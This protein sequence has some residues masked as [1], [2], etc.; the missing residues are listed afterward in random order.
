M[1][2]VI[3]GDLK[4]VVL[5][6]LQVKELDP[7]NVL[8]AKTVQRLTP[9]VEERREKMKDEMM[10]EPDHVGQAIVSGMPIRDIEGRRPVC[11]ICKRMRSRQCWRVHNS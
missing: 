4:S 11:D 6:T 1:N 9:I 5:V 3:R 8:A 2:A 10:G 7:G